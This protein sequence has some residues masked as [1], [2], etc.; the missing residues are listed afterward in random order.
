MNKTDSKTHKPRHRKWFRAFW[1][2]GAVLTVMG[3][4]LCNYTPRAY[5]PVE[6]ENPDQISPYLTHEL[7]PDFFNN[8]QLDEPFDLLVRQDGLN[9]IISSEQWGEDLGDFTFT[10][11]MV[12]LTDNTIYLMATLSYKGVSSVI[13]IIATPTMDAGGD[14]CL[15]IQSVRMGTLPVTKLVT[16][17]AQKAFDQSGDCFEGEEDIEQMLDAIIRNE[18]FEPVFELS[19]HKA[20]ITEFSLSAGLLTLRFQPE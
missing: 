8:I 11:P 3:V 5:R 14:I 18:P 4:F 10:D 15:N 9:D 2:T 19:G 17:V 12:I 20:R 7:G 6:P 13:T 1:V 16:F